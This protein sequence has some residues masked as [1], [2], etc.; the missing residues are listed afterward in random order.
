[1]SQWGVEIFMNKRYIRE[2]GFYTL[3]ATE[4]YNRTIDGGLGAE[5]KIK[6]AVASESDKSFHGEPAR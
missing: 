1:M 6:T 5:L 2:Y 3:S 4:L